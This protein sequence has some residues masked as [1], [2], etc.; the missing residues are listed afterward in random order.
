MRKI[1][2]LAFATLLLLGVGGCEQYWRFPPGTTEDD[3]DVADVTCAV[4]GAII[5]YTECMEGLGYEEISEDE[6][7]GVSYEPDTGAAEQARLEQE[8]QEEAERQ[9]KL[10]R[11][12]QELSERQAKLERERQEFSQQQA[13]LERERQEEAERQAKL[14]RE[15]QEEAERQAKLERERQELSAR[16]AKLERERREFSEQQAE[17]KRERQE[18]AER[19]AKLERQGQQPEA[20]SE[21]YR[22]RYHAL[23][24]GNNNYRSL[25]NLETARTDAKTVSQ[26][27]RDDYGFT[28]TTLYDATRG[29]ILDAFDNLRDTLGPTDNLLVYYAGH[30]WL[31]ADANQGYWLPVDATEGK[32]RDW[33]SNAD[34]TVMLRAIKAKHVIVVADS[35]YSGTLTRGLKLTAR[36]PGFLGRML[37]KNSRTVLASGGL[38][39]VAD[40]GGGDH[41]VFASA[42]L[43]TL[44]ENDSLIDGTQLFVLVRDR[45]R[46][47]ADQTPAYS[48]IQKAGHELGGDFL[49]LRRK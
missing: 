41:S 4:F 47:A 14:E 27:L 28:V 35:C 30:G 49:F 31:D 34:I 9:A 32:R 13:K 42:F 17:L 37:K 16:Q 19:L 40:R 15:R 29:H 48:N 44:R 18:E 39:P 22:R 12:R 24:I 25:R 33:V 36:S 10:E 3:F 2:G 1:R 11:E 21:I 38:E 7:Y 45:V 8:R 46:L 20:P 5:L 6:Y 23:V 43:E 26:V